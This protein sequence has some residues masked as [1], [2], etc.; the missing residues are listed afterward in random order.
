MFSCVSSYTTRN[1]WLSLVILALPLA[2]QTGLGTVQ[3]TVQDS[4]KAV[5][6][7]AKITLKNTDTGM[8]RTSES[9]NV[10]IYHISS[11]PIGPYTLVV[12]APGFKTWSSNFEVQAG[13][14]VEVNPSMDV[15]SVDTIVEVTGAATL[16]TTVG[17]QVSDVK[18]ALRIHQLPLNGRFV[19][20]L[21]DL[22]PGVEGGGNPRVNGMKVGSAE[23]LLD[24]ISLVDRFGGGISRVQP[25]L[26]TIQEYRIETAGSGAQYSRPATISLV[27]KSGT[28]EFHGSVYETHRNNSG[29]LRARQRQDG[30]VAAKLIRNEFGASAGGPIIKNKTFW[31]FNYEGYRQREANF[32]QTGVPTAAMWDGDL[33]NAIDNNENRIIIYDPLTTKA[34][35][36]RTPFPNNIIPKDRISA[37]ARTMQSVSPV[38]Q[39]TNTAGNP[40]LEPN[41]TAY[42]PRTENINTQTYKGDHVFSENDNLSGRYTK[43]VRA[44]KQFGARYGYPKIGSTDAGGTGRQDANVHS[45][46]ARWNHVVNPRLINEFQASAH[47]SSNSSGTLAD[48]TNWANNLGLPN[49]FG[50]TG[51]P[52]ICTDSYSFFYYGCWD[53]DNRGDQQL[54]AYQIEDNITWVKGKHTV[55]AGFKGR[56]EYNNV[57]ELQQAQGSH[58]FYGAWTALYDTKAED[59]TP[60]TGS[61]FASALLGLP[62]GLSNQY[63]RGY[64]YF[65]Q[66]EFGLYVNDSWKVGRR[67]TV[68]LGVRWD[69]W[70][71]YK[72]KL[73]RLVNLDLANYADKFQVISPNDTKIE[74]IRGIPPSVLQSWKQR[75]LSWVTANSVGFPSALVPADNNNFAPRIGA[76]FRLTDK[77]V[78][79][80]GYGVYYWTMPLSQILQSSRTNPPLNLRFV[81]D[82]SN[83]NGAIDFYAL[84]RAP[85]PDDFV[86][87]AI[88]DINGPAGIS[89]RAQAMM[90][91]DVRDWADNQAQEWTFTFERELMK[92]TAVRFSYIGN[93]G[94]NL[95]QR[96]RWNDPESEYNY[97]ARTGLIRTSNPDLRRVNPNWDSGCCQA[98][99]GHS[100]YSNSH[101]V[102]AHIERRY[103]SG[104]AYQ[105]FYVYTHA[106]TTNDTGGFSYGPS[107]INSTGSTGFAVPENRRILGEPNLSASDRLRLGYANSSEVPPHR[108][109]WNAI[110]ELPFGRGKKFGG[111]V[112]R[113]MN[114]LIGGWQFALIG[115]WQSGRWSSVSAS[116]YLFGD[117]QLSE[118]QRLEMNVFGRHQRLWFKGDFTPT[119]ATGV[120]QAQLQKLIPLDR[121]QRVLRP[122]GV[123]FDNRVAQRLADGT[124]RL[125]TVTDMLNWNA[126]NFFRGP[127][128][129]NDDVSVFKYFDVTEAVKVRFTADFFNFFNHP[130][131]LPP[132]PT[133]GLQ[134]LSRQPN[135][136]RILQ[137]SLRVQW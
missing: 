103:S 102:Q 33:S 54:T 90:A 58:G 7:G 123:D 74:D 8:I 89:S 16:V 107:D 42:Y 98:P 106:M 39:G 65:R 21:F 70:T 113:K 137:F 50:V 55:K 80:A 125:T 117:P 5:L 101:S 76:A 26:D 59:V 4:T 87:K 64:F 124:V 34:D 136:P 67:L 116:R 57:R 19:T 49:P 15:G 86:G 93:H 43:S 52:T 35:G 99:L 36:T 81:N 31:F 100:G 61:G 72:E 68:D 122:V 135:A 1:I 17:A 114:A 27:T 71:P 69:K 20:N 109:R 29:G 104:L 3:G 121:A 84:S 40:W 51:W 63:N 131:D 111:D 78:V 41:F 60:F 83:K 79:R 22:T 96:Y 105:W 46:F 115:D 134:D 94:S 56:Q 13:Q 120:D 25:G 10:G 127:G 48:S 12:E 32:A 18:D 128:A 38:P 9:S 28:N 62:T 95:E 92:S 47:R 85:A 11:V 110:Y 44:Q 118:D 108:V 112:N 91:M 119:Q 132:D 30:S 66:K 97:Q 88:V 129:W 2:A 23:M 45:I 6:A 73:D 24:G 130:N 37:F 126:R 53:A 14:T 77:W 75:G 133:T 82:L